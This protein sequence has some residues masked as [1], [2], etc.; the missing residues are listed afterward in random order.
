MKTITKVRLDLSGPNYGAGIDAVQNDNVRTIQALL[1]D[2]GKPWVVPESAA[3]TV[4]YSKLDG[5]KGWYDTLADGTPAVTVSGCAVTVALAGQMLTVPGKVRAAI[6]FHDKMLNQ[7]TTFPFTVTVEPNPFDGAAESTDYIRLQWLE[8]NLD[9]YLT[10]AK[11]SGIFDGKDGTTPTLVVDS[12][13]Y[14]AGPS[15]EQPPAGI[16][17]EEIPMVPQ[18][19]YL[20]TR[21]IKQ[22]S[23]A[24]PVTDYSVSYMGTDGGGSVRSVCGVGPDS[25]GDVLLT[26]EEIGAIARTGGT[27]EG[28]LNMNAQRLTGLGNPSADSDAAGKSYVDDRFRK[29]SPPNLLDNSDFRNPVAQAGIGGTHMQQA[30]ATDRW[31]LTSGTVS[32]EA[33]VGLVL[34]GTITQKLAQT[35]S[36]AASAAVGM[37]SGN[38]DISYANGVVTI[39]SSGGT[40]AWAALYEGAFT[41]QTMPDYHPKGRL[42]ELYT[43]Q[44]Y[45]QKHSFVQYQTICLSFQGPAYCFM[46]FPLYRNMRGS[47]KIRQTGGTIQVGSAAYTFSGSCNASESSAI[48]GQNY[49]QIQSNSG[50]CY[51][52]TLNT[53]GVTLEFSADL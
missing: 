12:V 3:V 26:P 34:N 22:W 42:N 53:A 15:G 11:E 17:L 10:L 8:D 4:A 5:T 13:A 16:W 41:P 1:L 29:A 25:S 50:A 14:Q 32:H 48:I 23:G 36:G 39:T 21:R 9:K 46:Q 19:Q 6:L 40:I 24:E 43:C 33:G 30:Y 7:L 37:A 28:P 27:M 38:A 49:T 44:Y 51:C 31:I 52:Y 2:N 18:G 45:Y 35:P 20:W 47:A